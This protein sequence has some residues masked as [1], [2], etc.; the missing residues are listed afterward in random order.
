MLMQEMRPRA[1]LGRRGGG[2]DTGYRAF[3]QATYPQ[4]ARTLLL[5]TGS[6]AEAEDLAQEAMARSFE[7]W[8]R[9]SEMTSPAGYVYRTAFNLNKKRLRRLRVRREFAGMTEPDSASDDTVGV[10]TEILAAL[11][12]LPRSQREAFLMVEWLGFDATQ[13]GTALGIKA[14]SV[15][16]RVHR[17]KQTLRKELGGPDD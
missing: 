9:V 14:V 7:R 12:R 11:A 10:R 1:G 13:A 16:G 6:E 2:G 3:F 17:A 5:L 4:L 8:G 15:R